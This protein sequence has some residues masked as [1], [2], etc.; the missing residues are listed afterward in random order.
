MGLNLPKHQMS[1]HCAWCPFLCTPNLSFFVCYLPIQARIFQFP[2]FPIANLPFP[3]NRD[4]LGDDS[5]PP[6][7]HLHSNPLLQFFLLHEPRR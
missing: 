5:W 2:I 3:G 4:S 1:I 6:S 7:P